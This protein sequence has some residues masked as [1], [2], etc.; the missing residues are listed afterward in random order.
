MNYPTDKEDKPADGLIETIDSN[1]LQIEIWQVDFQHAL[2]GHPEV[3][4][5]QIRTVL[6]APAVVIQSKWSNRVCL[7]YSI[8]YNDQE[9]GLI[10]FCVV[11]GVTGAGKGK[12]ETAYE[13]DYIKAGK[14]IF[15][16]GGRP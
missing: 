15:P 14:Q 2:D 4:I 6:K 13:T 3:T 10:Y 12:M 5:D 8:P 9:L 7:F 16:S 1:G 11:V